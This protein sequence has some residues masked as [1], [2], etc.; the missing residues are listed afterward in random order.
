MSFWSDLTGDTAAKASKAAAADTYGKQQSAIGKLLGYGDEYK[1]GYD[2][3]SHNYDPYVARS[4]ALS[5][6]G[7]EAL[8]NLIQ[9]P[10][11]VR[12]LPGYQF[13]QEEG[14]RALDRSAAAPG[15]KDLHGGA[16]NRDLLRFGTGLADKTYGDQLARLLGI[17]REGFTEGMAATGAG[18]GLEAEG[19]RGQYGARSTAYG[20]DMASAGTIGQGDIAA[21]NAKAAGSQNLLNT[22]LK[23]GGMALGAFGGGGLGSLMGGGST[24]QDGNNLGM[25][26]YGGAKVGYDASG[27]YFNYG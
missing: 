26:G 25:G 2:S 12:S 10:S 8:L 14:I 20:G 11:S 15:G 24:Y 7:N 6:S 23:L 21:A 22:G 16:Q 19:L 4:E 9:N 17:N 3:L 13:D 18:T 27:R 5:G 1:A